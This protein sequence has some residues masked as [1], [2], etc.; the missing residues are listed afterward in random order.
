MP[1]SLTASSAVSAD[2]ERAY[3]QK[4]MPLD[5]MRSVL[6]YCRSL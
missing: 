6:Q 4:T 3:L 2:E 1:V 5:A